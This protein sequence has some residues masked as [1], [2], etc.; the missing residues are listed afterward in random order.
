MPLR[1]RIFIFVGAIV[2]I[3]IGV[4][5]FL[6]YAGKKKSETAPPAEENKTE[7]VLPA[8]YTDGTPAG[9]QNPLATTTPLVVKKPTSLE[10]QKNGVRQIAKIFVERYGTYST[11][12]NYDNIR[13]LENLVTDVL[14]QKISAP[15]KNTKP[16]VEFLGVTTKVIASSL[17]DWDGASAGV[18]LQATRVEEKAGATSSKQVSYK[19]NLLKIGNEWLVGAVS[20][21]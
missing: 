5:V 17:S 10:A 7:N 8:A 11:D 4:S 18:A 3:I 2:I 9:V 21:Q 20:W 13:E 6:T 12:N 19:V 1:A 16:A 14:W 15:L